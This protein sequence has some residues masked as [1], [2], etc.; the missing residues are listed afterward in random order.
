[1]QLFKNILQQCYS[2][3]FRK[4]PEKHT[5][6]G[7]FPIELLAYFFLAHRNSKGPFSKRHWTCGSGNS[8]NLHQSRKLFR[9]S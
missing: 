8:I 7:Y 2:K 3:K 6:W 9:H 1:M 5:G 4:L